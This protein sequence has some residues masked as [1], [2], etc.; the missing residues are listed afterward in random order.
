ML[1]FRPIYAI[2]ELIYSF[3][4]GY[5]GGKVIYENLPVVSIGSRFLI[6][7]KMCQRMCREFRFYFYTGRGRKSAQ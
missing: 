1:P 3:G 5:Y 7:R 2:R 4:D 6:Q